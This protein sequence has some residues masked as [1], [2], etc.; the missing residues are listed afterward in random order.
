MTYAKAL[1]E[2]GEKLERGGP[3]GPL[4][5]HICR[6]LTVRTV[7]ADHGGMCYGCFK[8]YCRGVPQNRIGL[9]ASAR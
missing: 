1:K 7:L 2:N 3:A 6:Q 8:D 9:K 5:C 4:P